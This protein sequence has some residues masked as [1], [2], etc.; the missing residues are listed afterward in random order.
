MEP[1]FGGGFAPLAADEGGEAAGAE[2]LDDAEGGFVTEVVAEEGDGG[3]GGGFGE[4]GFDG[5][6]FVAAGA[7][8]EAGVELEQGEAG[9]AGEGLEELA[10]ALLDAVGLLAGEAAPVHDDAVG[11]VFNEPAERVLLERGA[12]L[13]EGLA[14]GGR[15]LLKLAA[16]VGEEALSA[17]EAQA[18]LSPDTVDR[19]APVIARVRRDLDE[20]DEPEGGLV[21]AD[22][23]LA[24]LVGRDEAN[25]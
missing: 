1:E 13:V 22:R 2:A 23:L 17:V 18:R 6:A 3:V 24:W 9:D 5:A 15:G 20:L 14:G 7:E 21:A 10:G 16:A 25:E 19:I 12:E 4:D 8:F 11:L